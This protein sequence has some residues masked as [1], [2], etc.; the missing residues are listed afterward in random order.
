MDKA[1]AYD[2]ALEKA[3]QDRDAYQKE[4]DKTDKNSQLASILKAGITAIEMIFP[5]LKENENDRIRKCLQDIVN[6]FS[7]D[8]KFFT[9]N[10]VAKKDVIAYL[11]KQKEQNI[12]L[13]EPECPQFVYDDI[14]ALECAMG[15][16]YRKGDEQELYEAL[17][18]LHSRL[19][20]VLDNQQKKP[21]VDIDKLRRDLY[22]S[23]Y[24]DGY[25]HGKEDAQKEQKPVEWN[26]EDEEI[27]YSLRSFLIQAEQS[28][29]YGSIQIAQIEQCLNWLK[30]FRLHHCWKPSKEKMDAL[31]NVAYG[32]Y[33]N[34][35]GPALR[36]LYEQLL[37][38]GVKEYN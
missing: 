7:F 25:Q 13:G 17:R 5:Q 3:R 18:S 21:K 19:S 15:I 6:W 22:Q 16:A 14:L 8:S 9:N 29:K 12:P 31:K 26:D 33:Q 24:N 4:L 1:K 27:I 11:E 38:L 34:G 36:E 2:E 37:K 10:L 28:G 23:G 32:T 30:S 35:D 20:D